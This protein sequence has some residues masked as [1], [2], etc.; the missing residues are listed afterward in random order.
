M[1]TS[2][3]ESLWLDGPAPAGFAALKG[4]GGHFDAIVVGGGIA[5]LTTAAL[6][7][8]AGAT[9]AVLEAGRVGHGVTGCTTAKV[10]ALQ[11]NTI[12]KV[13]R[14]QG[15][16]RAGVYAAA[17]AAAV[18][19]VAR[20]AA[21]HG[22]D[23][24]LER[25]P[26]ETLAL[27][28]NEIDAVEAELA[29]AQD[30]G[31]PVEAA[32]GADL[33]FEVAAVARLEEQLQFQ[34]VRYVEGLARAVDGDGSVVKEN[35]RVLSV[36]SGTPCV[37][38]A[39]GGSVSGDRVVIA[40]HFP[41]LDRGLY[42]ATLRPSRSYCVAMRIAEPPPRAMSIN[43]GPPKRS[44]RSAG[45]LLIVSGESHEPG[46]SEARLERFDRLE[47][48]ARGHW[49]V[50]E[51]T[52]RWSAQDPTPYDELP[53]VGPYMPGASRLF[54]ASGFMKWG[55]TGGTFAGMI[56]SGLLTEG[57]H[58]W[59]EAFDPRRIT[60]RRVPA[61]AEHNLKAARLITGRLEPA[62]AGSPD[63]VPAGEARIVRTGLGKSG[64][65]RDEGGVLHGVSLRCT[66][67]GCLVKFNAAER[68]WDCP[69]HGSRFD[70]D[71]SVLEGPATRPLAEPG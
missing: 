6:L 18:T 65:F 52:H 30:A 27:S 70:L 45:E 47:E 48:F 51:I 15:A 14:A 22:I 16:E 36:D 61:L 39:A 38:R 50:E 64:Y 7:K 49:Q 46:S 4:E 10:T 2:A 17:S 44:I 1:T 34:P 66:H 55:L 68:S 23:C 20:L 57:G 26:A 13:R 25:R 41:I 31:L 9:V 58:P 59:A 60:L 67:L 8:G 63:E 32:Q 28:A 69:C 56:L 19:E 43:V 33:P 53:V 5:G 12:S 24:D 11:G 42:F 62:E 35:T 21:L 37:V 3:T 71:G 40:T 29:A 54:V